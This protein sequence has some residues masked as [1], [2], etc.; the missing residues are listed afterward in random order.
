[1]KR[2]GAES[3][4]VKAIAYY[5]TARPNRFLKTG[6]IDRQLRA[7]LCHKTQFPEGSDAF[8]EVKRYLSIR[9]ALF[10]LRV[11]SN[12]AEGFRILS[13]TAMHC[14]PETGE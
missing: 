1:M 7:L 9:S 5:M 14:L 11:C 2:Y 4:P 12:H 3:A 6:P 10:G 8:S 13:S